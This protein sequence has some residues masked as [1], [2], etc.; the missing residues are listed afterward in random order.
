MPK[1]LYIQRRLNQSQIRMGH[2][3]FA[4][5]NPDVFAWQ[6]FNELWGNGGASRLFRIVRTEKG[7]AY[8]VGSL[9]SEYTDLGLIVAVSL[10]RGPQTVAAIQAMQEICAVSGERAV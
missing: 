3:G 1:L 5:H 2:T 9:F 4:R 6:V 7:L 8:E 10:T